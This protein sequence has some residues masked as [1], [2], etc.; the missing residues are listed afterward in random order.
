MEIQEAR[1]GFRL[2]FSPVE[3]D[4]PAQ[5]VRLIPVFP[6]VRPDIGEKTEIV[7]DLLQLCESVRRPG[8]YDIVNCA[9]GL[10]DHSDLMSPAFVAHPDAA[11][12]VWEIDIPGHRP[13]LDARWREVGGFLRLVFRREDYEADIRAMLDAVVNAGTAELPIDDY[14]PN[15]GGYVFESLQELA[16]ENKWSRL[17]VLPPGTAVEFRVAYQHFLLF[18]GKPSNVYAPRLFT[19]WAA[20]AAFDRWADYFLL[21]HD[22]EE[23][24]RADCD[25]AGEALAAELRRGFAEGQTAPGVAVAYRPC[26]PPAA[27]P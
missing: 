18:D 27:T 25:E 8:G 3:V 6:E 16:A 2:A 4:P 17:P 15:L 19:R 9:C 13:A 21:G 1:L 14:D 20:S 5:D 24:R 22:L 11:T 12:V 26:Q 23:S 10:G 7:W